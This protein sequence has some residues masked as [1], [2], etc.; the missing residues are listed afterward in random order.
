MRGGIRMELMYQ[1][2]SGR[3]L[4]KD[5]VRCQ[6]MRASR[7]GGAERE[8]AREIRDAYNYVFKF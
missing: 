7:I 8:R 4:L 5:L 3:Y 1:E 6:Q 2:K